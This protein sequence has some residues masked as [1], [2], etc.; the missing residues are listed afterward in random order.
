MTSAT[1]AGV[2]WGQSRKSKL[3]AVLSRASPAV[4]QLHLARCIGAAD[5]G[6]GEVHVIT[7]LVSARA[8]RTKG[9]SS[10]CDMLLIGAGNHAGAW[11]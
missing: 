5:F 8:A 11:V 10:G 7:V 4:N 2:I 1:W 9:T 3:Y 6:H